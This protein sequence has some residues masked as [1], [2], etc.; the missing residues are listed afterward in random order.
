[1]TKAPA[2]TRPRAAR[3]EGDRLR[4][5]ILEATEKLLLSTGDEDAVS[6][7][8]IAEAV[9]VT[10]P[11]IY[12]H[13]VDKETLILA[14]CQRQFDRLDIEIEAAL[15]GLDDPMDKLRQRGRAYIDFGVTHPEQ[16]RILMMGKRELTL[17][18][19]QSGILPGSRS[20][21]AV[22]E[23][24][25]ECMATG[26]M[27]EGDPMLVACGLWACVHG[28]T[29]LSITVPGFPLFFAFDTLVNHVFDVTM[30]GLARPATAL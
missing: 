10:P 29:S 2:K 27:T 22:V 5:E 15:R 20:L 6:M 19:F 24:I 7:R 21:I 17:E 12:L 14:V 9:G 30:N 26:L 18:D 11:S 3:G 23:N 13:F 16:Y 8:S 25:S 28:L 1:M 4:Q